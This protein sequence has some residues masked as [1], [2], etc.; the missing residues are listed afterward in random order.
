MSVATYIGFSF[1]KKFVA[2]I[3]PKSS[4]SIHSIKLGAGVTDSDYRGNVCV[5]LH[6]LSDKRIEFS[7]GDRIAQV[8]FQKISSPVLE[9]VLEFKNT[10]ERNEGCFDSTNS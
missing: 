2:K 10:T 4:L 7:V 5:V 6:N 1:S 8:V 9:E 3:H